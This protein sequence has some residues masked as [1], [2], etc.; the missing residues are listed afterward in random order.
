MPS[1]TSR[2]NHPCDVYSPDDQSN[3]VS[4]QLMP[5]GWKEGVSRNSYIPEY[6][7]VGAMPGLIH[8]VLE[9]DEYLSDALSQ[10][11]LLSRKNKPRAGSKDCNFICSLL[12]KV[13]CRGTTPLPTLGLEREAIRLHGLM[14]NVHDLSVDQAEMGWQLHDIKRRITSSSVLSA[15]VNRK[16][17]ALD[18]EFIFQPD[19]DSLLQSE[20]ED[21]FLNQWVPEA[22]GTAA[23]HWFTPQA[24][25][26]D[27]LQSHGRGGEGA[28]RVDFLF[29]HPGGKPFV[30]EI[31]GE[32]HK[33]SLEN[34]SSR[35]HELS[36]IGIDV[37]RVTNDEV[38]HGKGI[39]LMQIHKKCLDSMNKF[40]AEPVHD[41][42][43]STVVDCATAA[44]IQYAIVKAVNFGWLTSDQNWEIHLTGAGSIAAAGIFDVLQLLSAF[45]EL[46]GTRSIPVQCTV[47]AD[48]QFTISWSVGIDGK[49]HKIKTPPEKSYVN[50]LHIAIEHQAS[51]Y[52]QIDKS[53]YPDFVIRPGFLPVRFA[54]EQLHGLSSRRSI[55]SMSFKDCQ[56]SL[57]LLLRNI[58]RKYAFRH[59]QGE[60]IVSV[61]RYQDCV[62]LLPTGAGKSMIYQLAGLLMPGVTLVIDPI[63][64][65]IDDQVEGLRTY[66]ISRAIP[67]S[68]FLS[69]KKRESLFQ[70][71][72]LGE[73]QF[74]F[75]SPERLQSLAFQKSLRSLA[76]SSL[77]NL[78][79]IDEAHCV[80]EWGH[81]FRPA[82]LNLG[83]NLRELG[84]DKD[85]RPPPLLALT[86][87]ASR[88]VL[89]DL[90]LDLEIDHN[91]SDA[92]IRPS[93][94][95]REE[96][97]FTIEKTSPR[98]QP[99]AKL[100]GVLQLLPSKFGLPKPVFYSASGPDTVSGIVFVP[101]VNAKKYGVEGT[102][103]IVR[104]ATNAPVTI[105]A[106]SAPSSVKSSSWE[107]IKRSNIQKFK[108]NKIPLLVA[109]KAFGMGIDKANIRYTIH[110]GMPG[111]LESFYQETGRAGRDRKRAECVV[112][113][114]EYDVKQSTDLLDPSID[115]NE[116]RDRFDRM[117][118]V[119]TRDD[120]TR[121]LWFH[122]QSFVGL[123]KEISDIEELLA[124]LGD[125]SIAKDQDIPFGS[126]RKRKE[127]AI[128]RLI[129]I[130][131]VENYAVEF[132]RKIF[133]VSTKTLDLNQC[134]VKLLD[135]IGYAQPAKKASVGNQVNSIQSES[136]RDSVLTLARIFIDFTYDVIE[137]SRRR[138]IQEA[139]LLARQCCRDEDIRWRLLDYLQEGYGAESID[140]LLESNEIDFDSWWELIEKTLTPMDAG[141]LRGIC[142]RA[143][144]SYP[145]HPGLLVTRAVAECR[146]TDHDEKVSSTGLHTAISNALFRYQINQSDVMCL[147]DRLFDF[148]Y[149][150]M[151]ELGFPL[152]SALLH[153]AAEA[154]ES[155]I[156]SK[157][158]FERALKL[159]N[160]RVDVMV[161]T[162]RMTSVVDRLED[163][164]NSMTDKDTI[165]KVA[166]LLEGDVM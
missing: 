129:R 11:V 76:T 57:T 5:V 104:S 141:Q 51:P 110:F 97:R 114:S 142:I 103:H 150:S 34:D 144:E 35:D 100:Q 43:V 123:E 119:S 131:V 45:D 50:K 146:C 42:L 72:A 152:T 94:F 101:T 63:I 109:T 151:S 147:I 157:M 127:K 106:G 80:S 10:F 24:S 56:M 41:Q 99:E 68:G 93:S 73:Y 9:D 128:Y 82:Y 88:A 33:S 105:Y 59:M 102:Q 44:K 138:M 26:D 137:R 8:D 126:D 91:R 61:L 2:P 23:G 37:L 21:K 116:L 111:S 140:K 121:A 159:N 62:V 136:T 130:G 125:L 65:L 60:A 66:G 117:D 55:V 89:R 36:S 19:S 6:V 39:A 107:Q 161:A 31:D 4:T 46:Y 67:I 118:Q 14:N 12:T 79:V 158:V 133:V 115:L 54:V 86:G 149:S 13:L 3:P 38:T 69:A 148:A 95:D 40:S 87:T 32:D 165:F 20:A 132:G 135:Y 134:K 22:L 139:I 155:G 27:L 164:V 154:S 48:N 16:A 17:F 124:E 71:V 153:L 92:L 166:V 78:A 15:Y 113:F 120:V 81:D 25:L 84:V 143:L 49:W 77:I 75:I 122:L 90:L 74:V 156:S 18:P 83:R 28:R 112:I 53:Q 163:V 70:S 98:E 160:P 85:D 52:H 1:T 162:K 7:S 145:D 30:I 47:C 64:S 108:K 96:L 58:F 29:S